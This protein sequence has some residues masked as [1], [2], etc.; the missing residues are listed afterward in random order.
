MGKK[1]S[2]AIIDDG[3]NYKQLALTNKPFYILE[4]TEKL[5]IKKW[6]RCPQKLISHATVCAGIINQYCPDAVINSIKVLSHESRKGNINQLIK[7]LYWCADNNIDIINLSL[8]STYYKDYPPIRRCIKDVTARGLIVIAALNNNN[9]FTIPACLSNVIGVKSD[10]NL[11]G[12]N[13]HFISE[14]W[15]GIDILASGIHTLNF[16]SCEYITRD[17]NSYAV[18]LITAI[19]SKFIELHNNLSFE[20]IRDL[21]Y[22]SAENYNESR[23][24]SSSYISPDWAQPCKIDIQDWV[25]ESDDHKELLIHSIPENITQIVP[26][27]TEIMKG[28]KKNIIQTTS[29]DAISDVLLNNPSL[30]KKLWDFNFYSQEINLELTKIAGNITIPI[31]V[32]QNLDELAAKVGLLFKKQGYFPVFISDSFESLNFANDICELIPKDS[33]IKNFLIYISKKYRNDML[34][35][36][37]QKDGKYI[38]EM[39]YDIIISKSSEIIIQYKDCGEDC[40]ISIPLEESAEEVY[41]VIMHLFKTETI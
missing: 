4:V 24:I 28:T 3:V 8:G 19:V 16:K 18:P 32:F 15:Y 11:T 36:N 23:F 34:I 22:K 39:D 30:Y 40:K 6:K 14:P 9:L 13:Y 21:L 17:T 35:C 38:K 37:F 1:V 27:L 33:I 31:L 12:K 2:I 5:K 41:A 29:S 20:Q 10:P 26:M 25:K 7:A